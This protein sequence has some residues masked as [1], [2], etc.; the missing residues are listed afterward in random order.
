M[1][2]V[3]Y[4]MSKFQQIRS[5]YI[6]YHIVY[7]IKTTFYN[8]FMIAEIFVEIQGSQRDFT[9]CPQKL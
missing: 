9:F 4:H 1:T 7:Y 5:M 8:E 6:G 3:S 2:F